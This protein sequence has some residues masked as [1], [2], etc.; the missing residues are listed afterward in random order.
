[1]NNV[2]VE[3]DQVPKK[4]TMIYHHHMLHMLKKPN[5]ISLN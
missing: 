1:M 2:G 5:K 3:V 4:S